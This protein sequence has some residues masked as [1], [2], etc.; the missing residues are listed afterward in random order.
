MYTIFF[1]THFAASH[2]LHGY[3]GECK[4]LHGH[5]WK[6][7]VEIT[8][9]Q[10]NDIGISMDFRQLKEISRSVLELLDHRHINDVPPFD[11]IN[12]T[13]E[14]LSKFIYESVKIKLPDSVHMSRVTVWESVQYGITYSE[15]NSDQSQ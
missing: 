6:V 4:D 1:E 12:P 5:T 3:Q 15:Q 9:D 10:T 11:R 2:Q 14:N 7:R 13:A 8:S